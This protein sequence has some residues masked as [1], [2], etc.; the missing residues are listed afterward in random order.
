MLAIDLF[1]QEAQPRYLSAVMEPTVRK[2]AVYYRLPAGTSGELYVGTTHTMNGALKAEGTYRDQELTIEH[3]R[4]VFYHDNGALESRGEYRY[5][6]KT[7]VWQRFDA[8]GN[9]LAEKVYDPD[10]L[11]NIIYSSAQVMPRYPEGDDRVFVRYIRDRVNSETGQRTKAK[12]TATFVVEKTGELTDVKVHGGKDPEV[13]GKVADA[14][15]TATPW[16]PGEE[17]GQPVRVKVRLPVN[18]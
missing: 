2:T 15:R 3:G 16:V 14:I 17:K 6:K 11:A 10:H 7:G 9:P 18:F 5:G 13:D 12:V 4:F 8:N 1:G